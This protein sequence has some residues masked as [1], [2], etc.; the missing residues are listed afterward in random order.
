MKQVMNW[1][2]GQPVTAANEKW[3]EHRD[4]ATGHAS[5]AW[6]DSD[7]MDVVRAVQA[8]NKALAS[9]QKM[10]LL[11]RATLLEKIAAVFE[12]RQEDLA[13][14]Q[15]RD[16]GLP[17]RRSRASVTGAIEVFHYY[18]SLARSH[19]DDSVINELYLFIS[20]RH[21]L[22][23]V[24]ALT[25]WS[26]PVAQLARKTAPALLMGNVVIAKPSE[27]TPES[28]TLFAELLQKTGLPAG[29]FNL[30]HGR[31][32]SVGQALVAHP[33]VATISFTGRTEIGRGILQTSAEL[34]K[35]TQLFLGARNPVLVFAGVDL[36]AQMRKIVESTMFF[37]SWTCLRGS[38]LFVQESIYEDFL[39][40]YK[41]ELERLRIGDPLL[42]E[43]DLGPLIHENE[44][45]RFQ[46]A[47]EQG[48]G[49]KGKLLTGGSGKPA[50]LNAD[51]AT[52]FFAQPSVLYDLTL[53]STLQQEEVIGPFVTVSSFKYQHDAIKQANTSPFAQAAYVFH[54]LADKTMKIATKIEAS[55]VFV[56]SGA[57]AWDPRVSWSSMKTSGLGEEGGEAA[58]RF[59]SRSSTVS[60]PL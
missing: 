22:G 56:N 30:I 49:E 47:V 24:A 37:E 7:V 43:T 35:K 59:F 39:A 29:V 2:A 50:Q 19:K 1:I 34:L 11:E 60:L 32:E 12:A 54:P 14:A 46:A 58:L 27:F 51:R 45:A 40:L 25:S 18:A 4:P 41:T 21:P 8:A 23:I 6:P 48:K 3:V 5:V 13:Q 38:R 16:T 26:D 42:D 55:R 31:G 9:W 33:G 36:A 10:S 15:S 53:C 57:P 17:I 44:Y 52:G 20:R 28:G